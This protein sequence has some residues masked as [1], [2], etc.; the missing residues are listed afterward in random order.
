[1]TLWNKIVEAKWGVK[2]GLI[3]A[4]MLIAIGLLVLPLL[5]VDAEETASRSMGRPG[6][7]LMARQ[8]ATGG[9]LLLGS[10]LVLVI[11]SSTLR[12]L[13]QDRRHRPH[14]VKSRKD[15]KAKD[16]KK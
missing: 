12:V 10:V 7:A 3:L 11:V 4:A 2:A 16:T 6:L 15:K 13:S 9:I 1:M 14:L 8:E 5:S